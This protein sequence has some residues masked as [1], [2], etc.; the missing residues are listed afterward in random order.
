VANLD[1]LAAKHAQNIIA[2]TM[3]RDKD[4][5]ENVLTKALGV[6]QEQ[7]IYAGMLYLLSRTNETEKPIAH[8]V[9]DE[10]VGLLNEPELQAFGLA[11]DGEVNNT[12]RLLNHFVNPICSAP[13]Q[14]V[15]LVKDLFEQTLTYARYSAKARSEN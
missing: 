4:D 9:R 14:T 10:L 2:T 8:A 12:Q 3:G 1:R 5:V 6:F 15:L 13:V 7:G 11:Y